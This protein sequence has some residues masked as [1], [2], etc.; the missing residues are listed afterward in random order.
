[1]SD[2]AYLLRTAMR[3]AYLLREASTKV[4]DYLLA[5]KLETAAEW[6]GGPVDEA[7]TRLES[8]HAAEREKVRVLT[9]AIK[10]HKD[11]FTS[12][13]DYTEEDRIL[14]STLESISK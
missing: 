14:W 2:I 7:I 5:V 1:M 6:M 12:T 3:S 11:S 9:E 8:K 4:D 10:Q 13:E